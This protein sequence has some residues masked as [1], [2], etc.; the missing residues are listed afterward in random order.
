MS[1]TFP[2][3]QPAAPATRIPSGLCRRGEALMHQ[4][5]WLWGQ[6][7][8]FAGGN[9]L[10]ALGF[11]R[12]RAGADGGS[13][14]YRRDYPDG[15]AV[16]L[17]GFGI[18][19]VPPGGAGVFLHRYGFTPLSLRGAADLDVHTGADVPAC[20]PASLADSARMFAQAADLARWIADYERE[21]LERAGLGHRQAALERWAK[22]CCGP[23]EVAAQWHDVA[24]ELTLHGA[25]LT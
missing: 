16:V 5:C 1:V 24:N 12:T 6:D 14:R 22:A 21:I 10:L 4:Q 13:T 8:R 25:S 2:S 11:E 17:W 20:E 23:T 18:A 9:L 19:F 7:I 3:M 15:L